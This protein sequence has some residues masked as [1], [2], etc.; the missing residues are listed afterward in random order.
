TRR[1]RGWSSCTTSP[2]CRTSRW[3]RCSG[4]R[5]TGCGRSGPTPGR[6]CGTR[7]AGEIFSGFARQP[8]PGTAHERVDSSPT[9][10]VPMPADPKRVQEVFLAAAEAEPAARAAVLDRAC[11]GDPELRRRA[12]ALLAA[13]DDP[14]SFLAKPAATT[15]PAGL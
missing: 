15:A 6:G 11:G 7:S 5:S 2:G 1:R 14:G 12:E 8:G 9:E 4:R 3:R 10:G 13:H